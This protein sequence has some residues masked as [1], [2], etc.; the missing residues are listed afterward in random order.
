MNHFNEIG[1]KEKNEE[2]GIP[3]NNGQ[4]VV[5]KITD[6]EIGDECE[7]Q[8]NNKSAEDKGVPAVI[9]RYEYAGDEL[10]KRVGTLIKRIWRKGLIPQ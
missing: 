8:Q 4:E 10:R 9:L 3:D 7:K 6:Q 2:L 5:E 1:N